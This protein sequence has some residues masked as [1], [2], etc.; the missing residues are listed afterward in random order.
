MWEKLQR[1]VG[2]QNPTPLLNQIF[3]VWSQSAAEGAEMLII[4][5]HA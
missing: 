2:L 4:D 5:T 1:H 3:V